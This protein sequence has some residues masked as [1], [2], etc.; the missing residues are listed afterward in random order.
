MQDA[1]YIADRIKDFAKK[2]RVSVHKVLLDCK[3]NSNLVTDMRRRGTIPSAETLSKIANYFQ[4]PINLLIG[5]VPTTPGT[6]TPPEI[7]EKEVTFNDFTYAM[8]NESQELTEE[9]KQKLLEMARFFKEQQDKEK[10][11]K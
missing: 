1:N 11:K 10:A 2:K 4:I 6:P 3:I 9:N 8:Y 7:A 5:E